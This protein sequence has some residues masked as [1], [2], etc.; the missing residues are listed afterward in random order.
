MKVLTREQ[1]QKDF[2]EI[3]QIMISKG[4]DFNQAKAIYRKQLEESL[5]GFQSQIDK[6]VAI[7]KERILDELF[8]EIAEIIPEDSVSFVAQIQRFLDN[9]E[10]VHL[11][12]EL[13]RDEN[14]KWFMEIINRVE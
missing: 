13:R 3:W 12:V 10:N 6:D 1:I 4:L 11:T 2:P 9:P 7:E 5:A 8:K 14:G